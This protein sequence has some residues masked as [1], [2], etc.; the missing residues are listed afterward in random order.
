[1][2]EVRE[3]QEPAVGGGVGDAGRADVVAL[4]GAEVLCA[5]VGGVRGGAVW[6]C[7][8]GREFFV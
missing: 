3:G 4:Q 7:S 2:R 8:E 1:M 5:E 6:W